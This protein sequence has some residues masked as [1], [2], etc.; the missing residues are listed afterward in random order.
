M[1]WSVRPVACL[2]LTILGSPFSQPAVLQAVTF[3]QIGLAQPMQQM[4]LNKSHKTCTYLNAF[5]HFS[6]EYRPL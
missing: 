1:S 3:L 2:A 4:V 5:R 6:I